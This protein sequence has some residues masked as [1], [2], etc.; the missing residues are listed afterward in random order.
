MKILVVTPFYKPAYIYGGPVQSI[1]ALCE[2][3]ARIGA[4][5]TVFTTDANG[6]GKRLGVSANQPIQVEG[7]EVYYF[8]H[9]PV[10]LMPL[11][12]YSPVLG[13]ACRE[14]I[15][16][17]DAAYLSLNWNYP[18]MMAAQSALSASVPYVF[19]PRGCLMT[20]SMQQL[21][22]QKCIY[23]TLIERRLMNGASAIHCTGAMEQVQLA[24]WHF[25]PPAFIVQNGVD[26]GPFQHL[27]ARGQL[28][29]SLGISPTA[30]VSL[31]VGRLHKMKRVGPMVQ[32]F[33]QVTQALPSAHLIIAGPDEDGSGRA[34]QEKAHAL[35]LSDRV[36]FTGLLT[37]TGLLQAYAEADLLVLLSHRENFG[38]V[39]A[40]AMAAGVPVLISDQVGLAEEVKEV[41]AG[42]MV[43]S[44]IEDIARTWTQMLTSP[45]LRSMGSRGRNLV[46][47]RFA[48]EV[49]AA[50]MI[51]LLS[52]IARRS[53]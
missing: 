50:Q 53:A 4:R 34:A 52:R 15:N 5:V 12:F 14:Q 17:F 39:V 16:Q 48:S 44:K 45:A 2:S 30:T 31:F 27:P 13:R 3:M 43:S 38:M 25:K 46:K 26:I 33:A 41:N 23:L 28:R 36:H 20:W 19:S 49:V 37:G 1:S 40:E 42:C 51:E 11:F 32:A 24:A 22:W 9:V 35:G 18:T 21:R 6:T 8:S 7:V 10:P 47:E 29:R